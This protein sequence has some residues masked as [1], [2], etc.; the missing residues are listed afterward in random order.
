MSDDL[1]RDPFPWGPVM[2]FGLGELRLAPRDFWAMTL[3]ELRA[4][5]GRTRAVPPPRDALADLMARY[6][7]EVR[8]G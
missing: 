8:H 3:P 2:R 1:P 7:D 5:I 4:A 6:P